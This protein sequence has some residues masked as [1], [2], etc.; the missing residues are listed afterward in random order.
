MGSLGGSDESQVQ[1]LDNSGSD[2]GNET[3]VKENGETREESL[4]VSG[5]KVEDKG[6][7]NGNVSDPNLKK[8]LNFDV[9]SCRKEDQVYA[10]SFWKICK[11]LIRRALFRKNGD[12][13]KSMEGSCALVRVV[14]DRKSGFGQPL[15]AGVDKKRIETP[16]NAGGAVGSGKP[17][18]IN[19][20]NPTKPSAK[21]PPRPPKPPRPNKTIDPTKELI[22]KGITDI[23]LLKK[24]KQERIRQLKKKQAAKSTPSGANVLALLFTLCF[25]VV[26]ILQGNF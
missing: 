9:E 10:E 17:R 24:A 3:A 13:T 18:D 19:E 23:A 16:G 7:Q 22:M 1:N 20:R 26:M 6:P 25:C 12:G 11:N 2:R 15:A 21:R 14:V 4:G 5:S 8:D